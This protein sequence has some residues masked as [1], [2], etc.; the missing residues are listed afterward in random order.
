[1]KK[2]ICCQ[3]FRIVHSFLFN[4]VEIFVEIVQCCCFLGKFKL[5]HLHC[6]GLKMVVLAVLLCMVLFLLVLVEYLN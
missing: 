2:I 3:Q 5:P 6:T 1:M 4:N